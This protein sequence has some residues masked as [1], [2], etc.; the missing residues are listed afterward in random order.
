MDNLENFGSST[1]FLDGVPIGEFRNV[2]LRD[3]LP[4]QISAGDLALE[5][6]QV[7]GALVMLVAQAHPD[8]TKEQHEAFA[9]SLRS[10]LIA[11]ARRLQG[12]SQL[13]DGAVDELPTAK[14]LRDKLGLSKA[15]ASELTTGKRRPSLDLAFRIEREF[16]VPVS[17]WAPEAA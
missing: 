4:P 10:P 12:T 15:Y 3:H 1:F 2:N 9:H 16:G 13:A 8:W 17:Y 6:A 14:E 5:I 11:A 7:A